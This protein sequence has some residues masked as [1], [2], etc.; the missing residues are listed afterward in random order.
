[1]SAKPFLIV[2]LPR[3]RTAWLSVL[4]TTSESICYHDAIEGIRELPQLIE[5]YKSD[6][7]KHIGLADIG[8]GFFL[9]WILEHISPR[10]LIVDRDPSDVTEEMVKMGLPRT[11][12]AD[13]MH[14]RLLPF[15]DHPLVMWVPYEALDKKRVIEKIYW[16]LM[17]GHAFD[18][19]RYEQLAKM[20]ITTDFPSAVALAKRNQANSDVLLKDIKPL[21]KLKA[22]PNV[23]ALH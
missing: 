18:E 10:T 3:S 15:K 19:E 21:I 1:M 20:N 6:F 17:P 4:C 11:N 2:G 23:R 12:Y 13:L 7:Y 22:N 16:H 9:G 8:L 14:E 5:R